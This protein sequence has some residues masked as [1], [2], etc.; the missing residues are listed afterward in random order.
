MEYYR[1][2]CCPRGLIFWSD[3]NQFGV[4]EQ[5]AGGIKSPRKRTVVMPETSEPSIAGALSLILD[6]AN[7]QMEARQY[8]MAETSYRILIQ[9]CGDLPGLHAGLGEALAGLGKYD[10]AEASYRR[11]TSAIPDNPALWYNF[12]VVLLRQQRPLEAKRAC[13]KVLELSNDAG[14]RASAEQLMGR[15]G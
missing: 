5:N 1:P 6:K 2:G 12:A 9:Q 11:A 7:E 10:D 15:L 3:P 14:M 13:S 4:A 8:A